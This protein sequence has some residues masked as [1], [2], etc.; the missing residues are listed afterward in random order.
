MIGR[1][2]GHLQA[3]YTRAD[4]RL[5]D[6]KTVSGQISQSGENQSLTLDAYAS[7]TRSGGESPGPRTRAY[8]IPSIHT[9]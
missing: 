6:M 7:N 1:A 9:S 8:C 3:H 5:S 2:S 4:L